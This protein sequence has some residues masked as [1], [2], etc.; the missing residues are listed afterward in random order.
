MYML[1][2]TNTTF[3]LQIELNHA[4]PEPNRTEPNHA[5]PVWPGMVWLGV[6][7]HLYHPRLKNATYISPTS[8]NEVINIIGH[9]I[10]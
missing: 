2:Y 8:Q 3:T 4:R 5:G 10:I 6:Y 9:D 7:S 1:S